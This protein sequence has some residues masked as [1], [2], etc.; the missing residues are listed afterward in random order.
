MGLGNERHA[1][2]ALQWAVG[3]RDKHTVSSRSLSRAEES[4][5]RLDGEFPWSLGSSSHLV[6][7]LDG[8]KKRRALPLRVLKRVFSN[9]KTRQNRVRS[10]MVAG[11]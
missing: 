9:L 10:H 8:P 11:N 4:R 7:F 1:P 2:H 5:K 3:N 6:P